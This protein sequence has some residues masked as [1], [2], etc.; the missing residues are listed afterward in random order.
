MVTSAEKGEREIWVRRKIT[1]YED[2]GAECA[3]INAGTD[4]CIPGSW[5]LCRQCS[6]NPKFK[7]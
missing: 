2:E 1:E 7:K 3:S 5:E 4:R 6:C